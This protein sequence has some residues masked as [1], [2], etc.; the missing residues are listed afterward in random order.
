[1]ALVTDYDCWHA[2]A[3]AVTVEQVMGY[4]RANAEMAQRVLR[5]AIPAVGSRTRDCAC[6]TALQFAMITD[7]AHVPAKRR[8]ELAPLIGKYVR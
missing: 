2:S 8:E 4:L 6:A 3:E 5:D 7:L 1:M